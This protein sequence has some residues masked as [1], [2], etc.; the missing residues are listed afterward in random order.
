MFLKKSL[1]ATAFLTCLCSVSAA[2]AGVFTV[3]R[4]VGSA[5]VTGTITTNGNLGVLATGD[6]TDWDLLLA[7]GGSNFTLLGPLSGSNS[8]VSVTGSALS[9]TST[10]LLFDFSAVGYALFQNPYTG[11]SQNWWCLEGPSSACTYYGAGESVQV[12]YYQQG[13]HDEQAYRTSQVI[14]TSTEVPEPF[15]LS[16]FGTGIVGAAALRRRK[17]KMA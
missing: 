1:I 15:T 5:T 16:L 8:A 12:G 7:A 3:N 13:P 14:G 2:D 9:A 10:D 11:S 4:I 6:I 17:D